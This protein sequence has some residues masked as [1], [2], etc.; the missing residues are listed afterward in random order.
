M[1]RP[2]AAGLLDESAREVPRREDHLETDNPQ[3]TF[4]Y[5]HEGRLW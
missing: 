1:K 4:R 2:P 3:A 5:Y